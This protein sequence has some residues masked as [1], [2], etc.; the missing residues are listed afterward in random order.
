ATPIATP[1]AHAIVVAPPVKPRV[2]RAE[3]DTSTPIDRIA[4]APGIPVR[5][6]P[7]PAGERFAPVGA[8]LGRGKLVVAGGAIAVAVVAVML[9]V[10]AR[11]SDDAKPA[12]PPRRAAV[13]EPPAVV[14]P[15]PLPP[16]PV[17]EP[18]PDP[19]DGDEVAETSQPTTDIPVVGEGPCRLDVTTTPAGTLVLVDGQSIGPSPISIAGPCQKRRVDLTH[20]R[21]KA[22]QKFV[23]LDAAKPTAI[24]VMMTRPTHA[25]QVITNPP[26]ATISIGGRRAGTSPTVVQLMGFSGIDVKIERRGF[27]TVTKR[28]YS[29]KPQD[30]LAVTLKRSLWK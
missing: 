13:V 28:V 5:G 27:E 10:R 6:T 12:A 25:L 16:E 22:A 18:E 24:D 7:V 17:V 23:T 1:N 26:G 30:K 11:S 29:K 4:D 20:P 3:S 8:R 9:V 2:I 15:P 19:T 14:A 21:Y